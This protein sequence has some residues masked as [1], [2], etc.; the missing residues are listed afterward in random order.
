MKELN[1]QLGYRQCLVV[2]VELQIRNIYIPKKK[3]EFIKYSYR[4]E[5]ADEL[6]EIHRK[7]ICDHSRPQQFYRHIQQYILSSHQAWCIFRFV[8]ELNDKD[9]DSSLNSRNKECTRKS[10]HTSTT[11]FVV[12]SGDNQTE[13][14]L[15]SSYK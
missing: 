12:S 1:Y 13:N 7:L 2:V 14:Q 3:E 9:K 6:Q 15:V 4:V 5:H 10:T 11:T 8:P